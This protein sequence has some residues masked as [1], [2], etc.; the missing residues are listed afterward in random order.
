[1]AKWADRIMN[2]PLL[3]C[4]K[5][6]QGH[7]NCYC[8]YLRA[9][10]LP[11]IEYSAEL[12][13]HASR[14][15]NDDNSQQQQQ[16]QQAAPYPDLQIAISV[17]S[18]TVQSWIDYWDQRCWNGT[19]D[20]IVDKNPIRYTTSCISILVQ[21]GAGDM[22]G[23]PEG[24]SVP[25]SPLCRRGRKDR[26]SWRKRKIMREGMRRTSERRKKY[27]SFAVIYM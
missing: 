25:S 5:I 4:P 15:E 22:I 12:P 3:P 18:N 17:E 7:F 1:M 19:V 9:P 2:R 21:W 8:G 6:H 26:P 16:L 14:D 27:F 20:S 11:H 23:Y 13:F 24:R 10:W